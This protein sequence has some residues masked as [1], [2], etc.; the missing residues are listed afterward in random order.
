LNARSVRLP[1]D[2]GVGA[3][4]LQSLGMAGAAL[5]CVAVAA[6]A[7][8]APWLTAGAVGG[9]LLVGLTLA[10]PLWILGLMLVI[11][12]IDLSFMTG[13]MK[14]I[15]GVPGGIDMNGIRLIGISLA[16]LTIAALDPAVI[17]AALGRYGR[18]FAAFLAWCAAT[19]VMSDSIVDGLRLLLKLAYPFL[20]FVAILGV[21]RSRAELE[22]LT[23]W[24]IGGA[25]LIAFVINPLFVIAGGAEITVEG[26]LR[27]PGVGVHENPFSFYMLMMILVSFARYT[28]RRNVGYLL[29]C[30]GLAL[31]MMTTLT[32]IT[33]LAMITGFAGIAAFGVLA[34]RDWRTAAIAMGVA[35]VIAVPLI[36]VVLERTFW[37]VPT[38]AELLAMLRNPV[39]LFE[40]M[41]WQGREIYWAAVLTMIAGSPIVGHGLGSTTAMILQTFPPDWGMVVH[42]EYLRLMAEGG[43]VAVLLLAIALTFWGVGAIQAERTSADPLVREFATPAFAG[44]LAWGV[45]ALTDNAFDYYASFT[46]YIGFMAAAAV[47]AAGLAGRVE[48]VV[49]TAEAAPLP[50]GA[51]AEAVAHTG[52]V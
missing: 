42:N 34:R 47:A 24:I 9:V 22:R 44:L 52:A 15:E 35:A 28:T 21:A 30:A 31:W 14:A 17:G 36:P 27:I 33:L 38:A 50:E 40:S 29:L 51:D 39:L 18:W 8:H 10:R 11:G 45:I 32:R 23:D 20:L 12:P 2:A 1:G 4:L 49:A 16:L 46:Q 5:A 25:A 37:Y 41:N 26:R 13:G 3:R 6:G 43:L 7:V 48:D 19:L